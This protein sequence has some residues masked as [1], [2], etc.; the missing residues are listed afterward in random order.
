LHFFF[1]PLS[2]IQ[3]SNPYFFPSLR[4]PEGWLW[5]SD[6]EWRSS[7]SARSFSTQ[8]PSARVLPVPAFPEQTGP[9]PALVEVVSGTPPFSGM[10]ASPPPAFFPKLQAYLL[11][12][13][14]PG[15]AAFVS[16]DPPF[17]SRRVRLVLELNPHDV[18]A[19]VF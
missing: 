10:E 19:R 17:P 13:S 2:K 6:P 4:A 14:S 16:S 5:R 15:S 11:G 18:W 12:I 7:F 9:G 3:K 1:P 8:P